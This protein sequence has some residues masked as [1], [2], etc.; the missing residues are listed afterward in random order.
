MTTPPSH[1][2]QPHQGGHNPYE[3]S[4]YG[5]PAGGGQG[6]PGQAPGYPPGQ[7]PHSPPPRGGSTKWILLA[8]AVLLV[9]AVT[10]GATL[11]FTGDRGADDSAR[12]P[13]IVVRHRERKR[14][15]AYC[16]HHG[17]AHVYSLQFDKQCASRRTRGRLGPGPLFVRAF[18][19]MDS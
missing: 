5:A 13:P 9:I 2:W 19:D 16:N 11:F 3:Q 6:F 8:V 18:I 12:P 10:I 17:R 4:G 1:G 14:R 15:C 7:W